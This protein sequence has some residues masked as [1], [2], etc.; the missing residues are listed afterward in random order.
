[1]SIIVCVPDKAQAWCCACVTTCAVCWRF[2]LVQQRVV[3]AICEANALQVQ[4]G[5]Q[6]L[7][8]L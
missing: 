8:D 7:L 4:V 3:C 5:V 1:M 6:E 2:V